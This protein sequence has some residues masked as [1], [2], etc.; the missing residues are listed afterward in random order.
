VIDAVVLRV[1]LPVSRNSDRPCHHC[2]QLSVVDA[3]LNQLFQALKMARKINMATL[4]EST[5]NEAIKDAL[6]APVR[7][8]A[9]ERARY[10]S[11]VSGTLVDAQREAQYALD[12]ALRQQ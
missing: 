4:D 3:T 6:S 9:G 2:G 10:G 1:L 12:T 8:R 7:R 5:E 11:V